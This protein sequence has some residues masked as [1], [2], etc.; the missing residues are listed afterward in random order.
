VT[1]QSGRKGDHNLSEIY[2]MNDAVC[3][4]GE[5]LQRPRQRTLLLFQEGIEK[6]IVSDR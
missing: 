6:E 1:E 3:S 2:G 5:I 4:A